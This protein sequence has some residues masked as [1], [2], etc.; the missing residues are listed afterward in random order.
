ML[1]RVFSCAVIGLEGVIIEVEVDYS[2][3]LPTV[4]IVGLPDAAVQESRERVQ[5]A[6]KN[7]G[8]HF[9]RHRIVVNLSPAAI[10]KEGPAYDLPIALGVIMLSGNLPHDIVED[11]L[12]VG[13]LSLDGVVR[14]TRGILP[15]AATARANGFTRMFV[16]E[17]DAPEAAL[18]PDLDV[19]PVKTLADLYN[20]LSGRQL[21]EPYQPP[22]G[23]RLEPLFT[24]TDF[25]EV[26]GQ[27]H[28]K[29][30]LEVSAAGGHNVLLVGSPGAG[31]TLLARAMPGILPEMSIEES[32]D[33]TRIYSVADQL[34][35]GTPLIKHRPFRAP[36]HTISHAGLVGGGNIPKPGEI[37]LAHRGVLFL[38]EF[39][40][41][42]TRVLEVMRQ[43]MEDKVVTISRAKGSLTFSANFQLIAAMNPCPCGYFGDAQKACTCA[44]AAVTKYQK[45][46]SGPL[47]DRIDIHI[48]VPRVDYE[49][50]SG[51]RL[52]E[53]SETI[54]VRVQSA[55]DLQNKRFANGDA[56]DIVCNADMRV[57]EIRQFCKLQDEGQS[58]MRAAMTQHNLSARAYHRILKLARTIADLAGSNEIESAHLAEA[59]QYRPKLMIG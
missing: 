16:P 11:A 38:D 49:K 23:D 36:H 31:K 3:G 45:R 26:K 52:G 17:A 29:R 46:I 41:F 59:L 5:T 24:P 37:S 4:I 22:S 20:H 1:S 51:D 35:A 8:L 47:L 32:L 27:E 43:P 25:S 19:Y 54:R 13:E 48:E 21:I 53:T 55:R 9:P 40:E 44:H 2:N 33:V 57:G 12:V 50:L 10:R 42:G 15:M 18:I 30:A 7:A 14:H 6:I 56:S 34:P 28:V 39:P 58:L